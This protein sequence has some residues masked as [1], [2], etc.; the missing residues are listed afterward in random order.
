MHNLTPVEQI[1]SKD[2][3]L[4]IRSQ[5]LCK[6]DLVSCFSS[7]ARFCLL[8]GLYWLRLASCLVSCFARFGL[9]FDIH[10]PGLASCL[11][12]LGQVWPRLFLKLLGLAS[13]LIFNCKTFLFWFLLVSLGLFLL[14]YI[15]IYMERES[16]RERDLG[17]LFDLH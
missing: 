13:C 8:F 11:V 4:L 14:Y 3:M 1:S 15:C 6:P 9:I 5:F 7:L 10:L 12:F 17:V 2:I 16:E